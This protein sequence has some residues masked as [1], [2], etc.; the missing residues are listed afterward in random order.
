MKPPRP[1][2]SAAPAVRG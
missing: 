1:L 2:A